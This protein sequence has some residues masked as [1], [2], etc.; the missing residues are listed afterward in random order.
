MT[1]D[2]ADRV[3]QLEALGVVGVT[4]DPVMVWPDCLP[5]IRLFAACGTQWRWAPVGYG[6]CAVGLDYTAVAATA[7]WLG[8]DRTPHLLDDLR[9]LEAG[10]LEALRDEWGREVGAGGVA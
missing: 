5:A 6:A 8:L 4:V 10:A 1:G 2:G 3:Q 7:D 9:Q